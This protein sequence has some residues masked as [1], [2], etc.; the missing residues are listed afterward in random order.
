M[1]KALPTTPACCSVQGLATTLQ[2]NKMPLASPAP[3][4]ARNTQ[5]TT[6]MH[7]ES[8]SPMGGASND[9]VVIAAFWGDSAY[10]PF[11]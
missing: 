7:L 2:S 8:A 6:R 10:I 4:T 9:S 3:F 5:V 1:A 11:V